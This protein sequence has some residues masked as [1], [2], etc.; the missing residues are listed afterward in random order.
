MALRWV[1]R[2]TARVV[3]T[4]LLGVLHAL[5]G[6][7][8]GTA[9]QQASVRG[10]VIDR[11][12]RDG[13]SGVT[14]Q[15]TPGA[16]LS[17]EADGSFAFA[18][19]TPGRYVLAVR[20][21]GY[22]IEDFALVLRG[23]TTI[24][25]EL[26]RAPLPLDRIAVRGRTVTVRGVV[27]DG[28]SDLPLV[29]ADVLTSGRDVATDPIGRFRLSDVP[30][31]VPLRVEIRELGYLPLVLTVEAESDTTLELELEPDP[32]AGRMIAEAKARLEERS[33]ER[34]S[35]VL[36]EIDRAE[37]VRNVNRFALDVLRDRLRSRFSRISCVI[38]DEKLAPLGLNQLETFLPDR[39]EHVEILDHGMT[40]KG[41]MVR[42]YT[43]DFFADLI[44]GNAELVSQRVLLSWA[45][46]SACR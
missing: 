19:L 36:S 38:I 27:R 15:L 45:R 2:I 30:A 1:T 37:L 12:S 8:G 42:V 13:L 26:V 44:A 29:D 5:A 17:T 35:A 40:R 23:D 10:R 43:R 16:T 39:I 7:Q 11:E 41:L 14:V 32:I 20:G 9:Q 24:V 4:G 6:P 22:A 28:A 46:T 3:C 34:R 31:A 33:R 18:P 21:L 25:V